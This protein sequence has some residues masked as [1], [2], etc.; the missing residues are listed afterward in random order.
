MFT[1]KNTPSEENFN[2]YGKILV[3]HMLYRRTAREAHSEPSRTS[4]I[5]LFLQKEAASN[6]FINTLSQMLDWFLN[7]PLNSER[8]LQECEYMT[9]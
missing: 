4:T 2:C 8:L 7:T 9:N 5:K 3:A 6:F 1:I